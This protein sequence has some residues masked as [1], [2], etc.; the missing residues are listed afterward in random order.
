M[1]AGFSPSLRSSFLSW[2]S[3][4][5]RKKEVL[6]KEKNLPAFEARVLKNC[7]LYITFVCSLELVVS[8][9]FSLTYILLRNVIS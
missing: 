4:T 9:C 7:H 5:T 6:K 2:F 3:I 1:Q 8:R